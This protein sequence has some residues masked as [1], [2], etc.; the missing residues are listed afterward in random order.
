MAMRLVRLNV[1]SIKHQPLGYPLGTHQVGRPLPGTEVQPV[2]PERFTPDPIGR[3]HPLPQL[4]GCT[5]TPYSLSVTLDHLLRTRDLVFPSGPPLEPTSTTWLMSH[6]VH[7]VQFC[8]AILAPMS[9]KA[10]QGVN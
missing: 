4:S 8:F 9:F 3:G 5:Y 1:E 2:A 10:F 7:L 6:I